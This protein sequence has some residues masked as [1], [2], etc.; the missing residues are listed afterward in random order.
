VKSATWS[1]GLQQSIHALPILQ[2]VSCSFEET[3]PYDIYH[4][5]D[6]TLV[7]LGSVLACSLFCIEKELFF[8]LDLSICPYSNANF[9]HF[10]TK[11]TEMV[12]WLL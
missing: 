10:L 8:Y 12:D 6:I 5:G 11:Q 2:R 9:W 1:I 4:E 3:H 7:T